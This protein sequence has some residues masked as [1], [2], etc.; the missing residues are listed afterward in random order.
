MNRPLISIIIPVYNAESYIRRCIESVLSQT[1]KEIQVILIN[2]GSTDNTLSILEEYSRSDSRIQLINKDNSGVSKTRNIGIDIS[3]GEYIGFVD[4]DD[5]LEPEMYEKLYNAIKKTAADVACCGYYQDF[6][7]YKYEISVDDSLLA[8]NKTYYELCG[9]NNILGQYFRQ[10]IRSGIGDGNWNKLFR[11]DIISDI[12]YDNTLYCEDVDFQIKVFE[13]CKKV[14]CIKEMLYHYVDNSFSA[15]K[16]EFNDSKAGALNVVD[17]VLNRML[18]TYPDIKTQAYA[19]HLTWY[20]SVLQDLMTNRRTPISKKYYRI[21][22][23]DLKRNF[24][25]YFK[26]KFS[27]RLD[28][29]YFIACIFGTVNVTIHIRNMYRRIIPSRDI[30]FNSNAIE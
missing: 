14:V 21:I 30:V 9:T 19:F 1:Y 23:D 12:R 27:K 7:T 2:D 10:D 8:D 18:S 29:L 16:K 11:K 20:I 15:T 24:K 3:D 6:D 17:D 5:Y 4:A 28:Q 13:K 22:R 26:N 25:S